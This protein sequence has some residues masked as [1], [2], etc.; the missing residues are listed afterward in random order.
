M[1]WLSISFY[2]TAEMH[3]A[4]LLFVASI[5]YV[6]MSYV[7]TQ[8]AIAY[9]KVH[10]LFYVHSEHGDIGVIAATIL[11]FVFCVLTKPDYDLLCRR[12]AAMAL[13]KATVQLVT[14]VPAPEGV[15]YCVDQP[16]WT[17][18][19]CADMMFSGHTA[20]TYLV[21]YRFRFRACMVFFMAFELIMGNWHYTSDCI[22]AVVAAYAIEKKI[23]FKDSLLG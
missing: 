14:I 2:V 18:R 17:F 20:F 4:W 1:L 15:D 9:P 13:L 6:C 22:M 19:A 3:G 5:L 8:E 16:I 12:L 7:A 11:A 10:D 21:L 23:V